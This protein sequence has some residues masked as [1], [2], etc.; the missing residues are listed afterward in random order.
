MTRDNFV[1]RLILDAICDDHEN[2]D[3]VILREVSDYGAKCGLMIDRAEIVDTLAQLIKDGL[4]KAYLLSNTK[5][6]STEFQ[7]MPPLDVVE[8]DFRTYF[9]I[10]E[11][12]RS[13][14][15]S[16]ETWWPFDNDGRLRPNWKLDPLEP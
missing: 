6:F 10:T 5:P 7:G 1:R 9:Y 16:D 3:Q 14:H 15:L 4:A 13:L 12:G 8:A 2:V 11:K